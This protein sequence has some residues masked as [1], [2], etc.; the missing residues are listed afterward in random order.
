MLS[1]TAVD[2]DRYSDGSHRKRCWL[3][4][5][6]L[7]CTRILEDCSPCQGDST[8]ERGD[9]EILPALVW[10]TWLTDEKTMCEMYGERLAS[11]LRHVPVAASHSLTVLSLDADATSCPSGEKATAMTESEWPS[12]VLRQASQSDCS[13]HRILTFC[14]TWSTKVRRITLLSGANTSAEQ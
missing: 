7:S 14:G 6:H 1:R 9:K 10:R 12:S 11:V 8:I 2:V 5:I 3:R 13:M 4:D